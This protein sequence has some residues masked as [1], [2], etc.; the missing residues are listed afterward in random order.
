MSIE[1]ESAMA[2]ARITT[3]PTERIVLRK[4]FR[5]PRRIAFTGF[6]FNFDFAN[7]PMGAREMMKGWIRAG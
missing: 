4:A 6:P 2:T 3:T 1:M 5:M 7:S